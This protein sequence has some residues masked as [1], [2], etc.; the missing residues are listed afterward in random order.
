MRI[1]IKNIIRKAVTILLVGVV[2][3]L[4]IN[5]S[6][7]THT[8]KAANGSTYTHAHP[9]NS[10]GDTK[11]FKT[12][13]HSNSQFLFFQSLEVFFITAIHFFYYLRRAC[14]RKYAFQPLAGLNIII[15]FP[16]K[17]RAPPVIKY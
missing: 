3:T 15:Y 9:Y 10:T 13:H 5:K 17:D 2:T 8:H 7:Y 6:V 14:I 4:L 1:V 12:H 16:H 11:P